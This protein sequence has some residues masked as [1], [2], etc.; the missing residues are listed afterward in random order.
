MTTKTKKLIGILLTL[1]LVLGLLPGMRLTAYATTYV[2]DYFLWVG[3]SHVTSENL[4]GEG[5]SFDP[6]SFTLAL[7]DFTYSGPGHEKA[8]IYY[9]VDYRL[10]IVLQGTNSITGTDAGICLYYDTYATLEITGSGSLTAEGGT[11]GIISRKGITVNGGTITATGGQYGIIVHK[12]GENLTI[13]NCEL[14]AVGGEKGIAATKVINAIAGT[15]WTDTAGKKGKAYIDVST[16]GQK[17]DDYKKV[18]FPAA[19]TTYST[20]SI[21]N[22]DH[23][24]GDGKDAVLTVK[25][26]PDTRTYD[27]FDGVEMDGKAV[28][29]DNYTTANGSL[30]LTLKASYLDTLSAGDHTVTI[31]F[32][33]GTATANLKVTAATTP[34]AA[35]TTAPTPTPKPVPK[36]GDSG[37]PFLWLLIALLGVSLLGI[38]VKQY[39]RK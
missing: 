18:Q 28:S 37:T 22:A 9:S 12:T 39:C 8:A 13:K 24:I 5:W 3:D 36:T 27:N 21:A 25:G 26:D 1:A 6:V 23:T 34:T 7:N 20:V 10:K 2:H 19:P 32:K 30:V 15:G 31:K 17:L 14:T 33:D 35:P 16:E 38:T 4:S 29:A 11:T